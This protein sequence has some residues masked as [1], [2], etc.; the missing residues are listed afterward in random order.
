[1]KKN[2]MIL[3]AVFIVFGMLAGS[4]QAYWH[5]YYHGWWGPRVYIGGPVVVGPPAYP[6]GYYYAPQPPVV[7][8]QAPVVVA[9]NPD[10]AYWYYCD[11]PKGYYPY[12]NSCPGGWMKVVPDNNPRGAPGQ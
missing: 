7:V 3:L 10:D 11:N 1:M 5:G 8:Q 9:P 6:Y 2:S 12:V 4:A